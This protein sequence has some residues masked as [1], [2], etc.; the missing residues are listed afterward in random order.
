MSQVARPF[1]TGDHK[2]A[3]NRHHK[4]QRQTQN[5]HKTDPQKKHRIGTARN[6][7]YQREHINQDK[8]ENRAKQEEVT[9]TDTAG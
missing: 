3:R 8:K 7:N 5:K 4:R 1:L 6:I 2:A 9:L